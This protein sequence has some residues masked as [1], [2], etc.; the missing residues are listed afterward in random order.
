MSLTL[1]N[2]DRGMID[3][4][5]ADLNIAYRECAALYKKSNNADVK[6]AV[7]SIQTQISLAL[8]QVSPLGIH[9]EKRFKDLEAKYHI[10]SKA[11]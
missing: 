10:L 11:N 7:R 3:A 2:L 5:L 8:H 4:H 6:R 1:T 9:A